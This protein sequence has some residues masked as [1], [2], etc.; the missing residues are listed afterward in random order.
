VFE[1]ISD[2]TEVMQYLRN[3]NAGSVIGFSDCRF[4]FRKGVFGPALGL[5]CSDQPKEVTEFGVVVGSV[6]IQ[7]DSE[8]HDEAYVGT[9][10]ESRTFLFPGSIHTALEGCNDLGV[11]VGTYVSPDNRGHGFVATMRYPKR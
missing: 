7:G 1:T 11:V 8:T 6:R 3:N 5:E 2:G 9:F 4:L 10:S